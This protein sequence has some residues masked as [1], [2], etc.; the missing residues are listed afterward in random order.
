MKNHK[1]KKKKNTI[2]DP[3]NPQITT[4]HCQQ[5]NKSQKLHI[6]GDPINPQITTPHR[7]QPNKSQHSTLSATQQTHKKTKIK[8]K[9]REEKEW[10]K[11]GEEDDKKRKSE[12]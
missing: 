6:V 11:R 7:Q 3:T 4:P 1:K 9:E 12:K 10:D 2:D 5:P 8:I